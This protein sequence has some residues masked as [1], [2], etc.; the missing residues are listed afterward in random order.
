MLV[1]Q[2]KCS[3]MWQVVLLHLPVG[4]DNERREGCMCKHPRAA[5]PCGNVNQVYSKHMPPSQ[6][7][8]SYTVPG[9]DLLL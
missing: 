2:I 5:L 4:D 1:K 3:L 7:V 9:I 8:Y 6:A